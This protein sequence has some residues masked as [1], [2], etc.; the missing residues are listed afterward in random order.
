LRALARGP[1]RSAYRACGPAFRT[2]AGTAAGRASLEVVLRASGRALLWAYGAERQPSADDARRE[3]LRILRGVG[4]APRLGEDAAGQACTVC[5]AECQIGL[6]PGEERTCDTVMSINDEMLRGLG[7]RLVPVERLTDPGGTRCVARVDRAPDGDG[8]RATWCDDGEARRHFDEVA[9][10]YDWIMGFWELPANRRALR[11]LRVPANR[12]AR[13]LELGVGTGLGLCALLEHLPRDAQVVAVDT[14]AAMLA[15]AARRLGRRGLAGRV[16][17][18]RA[19]V[20]AL[21]LAAGGFDAVYS[22]FLLD[23]LAVDDRRRALAEAHRALAPGGAAWFVVMDAEAPRAADRALAA[24]YA[25]G[26]ARWNPLWMA[27]F[28]GY[29]PHCRP[30]RLAG[31][32][33][34][35]GLEITGRDRAHVTAF[36]VAIFEA[37]RRLA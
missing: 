25:T 4:L 23:L 1:A 6:G 30:V 37:T 33:E 11:R 16:T 21:P 31:L 10:H 17:L 5:F 14:S 26:Y 3:W 20:R 9:G 8:E 34:E 15:R 12:R 28:D 35:T 24:L 18:V 13:V 19:D 32:L 29:A 36:P 7:G 2:L 22:S 27:L